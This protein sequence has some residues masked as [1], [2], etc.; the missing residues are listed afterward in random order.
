[1]LRAQWRGRSQ[2]DMK[3]S[4]LNGTKKESMLTATRLRTADAD[5]AAA[6]LESA[7]RKKGALQCLNQ[8]CD[9]VNGGIVLYC[10]K[11]T[12]VLATTQRHQAAQQVLRS[13]C[14]NLASVLQST[15]N[16]FLTQQASHAR[17]RAPADC[18]VFNSHDRFLVRR[19]N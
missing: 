10:M 5:A 18:R 8:H 2:W 17:W 16:P 12:L 19:S 7:R 11:P 3:L 9:C 4:L 14:R 13:A 15:S 6:I 1:M